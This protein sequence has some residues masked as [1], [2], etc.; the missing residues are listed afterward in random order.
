MSEE[1]LDLLGAAKMA[2]EVLE[3]LYNDSFLYR[4]SQEHRQSIEAL[5]AAIVKAETGT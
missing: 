1:R 3:D 5:K 4:Y 2:L